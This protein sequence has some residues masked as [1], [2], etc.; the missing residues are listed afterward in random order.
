MI[1]RAFSLVEL[2]VVIGII[3]ILIGLLI[4]AVQGA[5]EAARLVQCR[6]HLKQIGLAMHNYASAFNELPSYSGE[7]RPTLVTFKTGSLADPNI[8]GS[9]WIGQMMRFMEQEGLAYRLSRLAEQETIQ[10]TAQTLETIQT[11]VAQLHCPSRRDALAYPIRNQLTAKYGP[12]GARNDYAM[13][14]GSGSVGSQ[15]PR[16]VEIEKAGAWLFGGRTRFN[17][18]LDGTS[19]TFMVGEKAMD[20]NHYHSGNG[21]GDQVPIAGNPRE[22]SSPCSHVRYIVRGFTLDRIRRNDCLVCHDFGSSHQ[23]GCNMLMADGAVRLFSFQT[24]LNIQKAH[25]SIQGGD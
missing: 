25:A 8:V 19:H 9:N 15:A 20:P 24:E 5:R 7:S 6:N 17:H 22:S 23:A 1:R 18:Y 16:W 21:Q 10:L 3:A 14:G 4:P 11:P 12:L 13:C 2:L